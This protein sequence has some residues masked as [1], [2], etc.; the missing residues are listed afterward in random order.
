MKYSWAS[1]RNNGFTIVELLIVIVIIAILAAVTIVA[2]NGIQERANSSA[3]VSEVNAY[4]KGFKIWEIEEGRPS[5]SSCIAPSSYT[6]CPSSPNWGS[7]TTVDAT[8]MTKLN[9]YSGVSEMKLGKWGTQ[10]P[11]GSMWYHA[12][13]FSDNRGVLYYTVGPNSDCGQSAVLTPTPGYDNMTLSGAKY[14]TRD[15]TSTRCMIEI[16]KW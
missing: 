6:T 14:T 8:F 2:F 13:Y 9:T 15:A 11:V 7:N 12:N 3:V 16:F 5:T 10:N 1:Y 4:V